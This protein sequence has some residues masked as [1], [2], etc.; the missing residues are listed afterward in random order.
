MEGATW[1][2]NKLVNECEKLVERIDELINEYNIRTREKDLKGEI[3]P[4]FVSRTQAWLLV[5]KKALFF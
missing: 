4:I 1:M 5:L 3:D 2:G